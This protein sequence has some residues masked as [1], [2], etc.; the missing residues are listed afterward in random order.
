MIHILYAV[1][2]NIFNAILGLG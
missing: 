1:T 2:M